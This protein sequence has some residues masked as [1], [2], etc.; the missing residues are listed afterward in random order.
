[1]TVLNEL[2]YQAHFIPQSLVVAALFIMSFLFISD[3]RGKIRE[4]LLGLVKQRWTVAFLFYA[5]FVLTT[6][7]LAR[8]RAA[9]IY[10]GVGSFALISK[11]KVNKET[12][13]NIIL[14]IPYSFLYIKAFRPKKRAKS[15]LLLCFLSTLFIESFQYLFWVGQFTLSD[16]VYNMIGGVI[17]YLMTLISRKK[18]QKT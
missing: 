5:A 17:G 13:V 9:P 10:S 15:V 12:L 2:M 7:V 11:G 4:R 16:I 3:N 18:S 14:F 8:Y 1:M 6:T